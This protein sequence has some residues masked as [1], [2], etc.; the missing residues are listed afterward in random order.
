M[1]PDRVRDGLGRRVRKK[2]VEMEQKG[3]TPRLD[4]K[5]APIADNGAEMPNQRSTMRSNVPKRRT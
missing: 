1:D 2:K 4:P 5:Y 3:L